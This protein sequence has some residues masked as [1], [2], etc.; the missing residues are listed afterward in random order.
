[1]SISVNCS[2]EVV[3]SNQYMVRDTTSW[4]QMKSFKLSLFSQCYFFLLLSFPF[5]LLPFLSSSG[6]II[7]IP[8]LFALLFLSPPFPV[9][10]VL[11]VLCC[12]S[13]TKIEIIYKEKI[14]I[15]TTTLNLTELSDIGKVGNF[16]GSSSDFF[17]WQKALTWREKTEDNLEK[18]KTHTKKSPMMIQWCHFSTGSTEERNQIFQQYRPEIERVPFAH[19][20]Q[21]CYEFSPLCCPVLLC[22]C[23]LCDCVC[24]CVCVCVCEAT[25]CKLGRDLLFSLSH[26][27]LFLLPLFPSSSFYCPASLRN[28]GMGEDLSA[29]FWKM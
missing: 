8:T 20:P 1:M 2:A 3:W 29:L 21:R 23:E 27:V 19:L 25:Q 28:D 4:T 14:Y 11:W 22:W 10:C 13:K 6:T 5:I 17:S 9:V 7:V 18:Q 16:Y 24:S 15:N 26:L 12:S